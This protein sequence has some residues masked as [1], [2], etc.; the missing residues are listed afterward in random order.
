MHLLRHQLTLAAYTAWL[1][2]PSVSPGGLQEWTHTPDITCVSYLEKY[3]NTLMMLI[4]TFTIFPLLF[5][6]SPLLLGRSKTA[7]DCMTP[8][9]LPSFTPGNWFRHVFL[10]RGPFLLKQKYSCNSGFRSD[11][12]YLLNT[13]L[14]QWCLFTHAIS[15]SPGWH[16]YGHESTRSPT[17]C[18]SSSA[19]TTCPA[20]R[21]GPSTSPDSSTW[22][23]AVR[24]EPSSCS[25]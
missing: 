23:G 15:V 5:Q 17:S 8:I 3:Q 25:V 7:L 18:C 16:V 19:T 10:Q 24:W 1:P 9:Y 21:S 20:T 22:P 14:L 4:V 13:I 11:Q 2:R 6:P 12:F